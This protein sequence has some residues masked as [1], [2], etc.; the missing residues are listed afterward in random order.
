MGNVG[1]DYSLKRRLWNWGR[2]CR[3]DSGGPDGSCANP[4]Y[5]MMVVRDD[6][7]YGEITAETV[8]AVQDDPARAEQEDIDEGDAESLDFYIRHQLRAGHRATLCVRYVLRVPATT[9]DAKTRLYAAREALAGLINENARVI[10]R[11][12]ELL[13]A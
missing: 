4:M 10:A 9:P 2:Y 6:E 1:G 8:I 3:A 5:Q 11:M 7:G 13:R 12:G